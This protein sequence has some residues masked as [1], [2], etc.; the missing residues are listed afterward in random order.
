MFPFDD[1]IMKMLVQPSL[2]TFLNT[3]QN[4]NN[5]LKRKTA[6]SFQFILLQQETV[7]K[8]I[9]KIHSKHNCGHEHISNILEIREKNAL[10]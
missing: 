4:Y 5:I 3:K 6:I 10:S 1:V 2:H 7:F 8:I 9:N